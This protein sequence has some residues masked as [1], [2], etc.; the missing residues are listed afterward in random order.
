M[1]AYAI[2][3]KPMYIPG[4]GYVSIDVYFNESYKC[5]IYGLNGYTIKE[6][7]TFTLPASL[8]AIDEE[9]FLNTSAST[10]II[11]SGCKSIGKKAFS[12]SNVHRIYIPES[13]TS[14]EESAFDGCSSV[15]IFCNYDSEARAFAQDHNILW[16]YP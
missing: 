4:Y 8:T 12:G 2:S 7:G 15:L 10:I 16:H 9:V 5:F 6:T 14:I 3:K 11:P 1:L 13:V